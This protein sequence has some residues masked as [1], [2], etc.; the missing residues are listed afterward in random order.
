MKKK[1]NNLNVE[2][3]KKLLNNFLLHQIAKLT[4]PKLLPTP[5]TGNC[6]TFWY[7]QYGSMSNYALIMNFI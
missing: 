2:F 5:P 3:L 1:F 4:T 7:H 6:F